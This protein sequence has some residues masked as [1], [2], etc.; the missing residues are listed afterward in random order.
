M[1]K[2]SLLFRIF[3]FPAN[4]RWH[5][6]CCVLVV[7]GL[8]LLFGAH[9]FAWML[10]STGNVIG[11]D[12]ELLAKRAAFTRSYQITGGILLALGLSS[13]LAQ[14]KKDLDG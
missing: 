6:I 10:E 9:D 12:T 3:L 13:G 1:K 14:L 5:I 11:I 4:W 8:V 2:R 7:L